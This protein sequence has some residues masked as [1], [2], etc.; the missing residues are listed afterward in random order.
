MRHDV[1]IIGAGPAGSATAILLARQGWHVTLV[2][3]H[4]FPRDKV[5]GECLS[6]LGLDCLRRMNLLEG[7][8]SLGPQVLSEAF[9]H[10]PGGRSVCLPLARPMWGISRS[11]LDE[12][13][14]QSACATGVRIIQPARCEGVL[15]VSSQGRIFPF[16]FRERAG[17]R[18]SVESRS[19]R[20][21]HRSQFPLTLALSRGERGPEI[22]LRD[23][24][25]NRVSI[26]HPSLVILADG[27][28]AL[29]PSAP[30]K[31]GDFG[32]KV[33]FEDI[34]GPRHAIE[35]FGCDGLYGGLA[36]IEGGR[37]NAAFSVPAR[38]LAKHRGDIASLF[39]QI[40]AENP[41]LRQ[42]MAGARRV[43][44]WLAAPLPRFA[45]RNNW[46]PGVIPVGNSAAALE[47]IGGEGMG[48]AL[49]SAEIVAEELSR[50][51]SSCSLPTRL[52]RRYRSQWRIRQIACRSAAWIVSCPTLA[53]LLLPL[54]GTTPG[55]AGAVLQLVGKTRAIQLAGPKPL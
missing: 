1:M 24:I 34:D 42:R 18:G 3:Q 15:S 40:V 2:E 26:E 36:A 12:F 19:T 43:S 5:C 47:P 17:V 35:L 48:L 28:S 25:T 21:E 50:S 51:D 14:L 41:I 39:S 37:W 38:R 33:H 8:R 54:L 6:A 16:S 55:L 4:R 49:C 9:I 13:L 29:M 23:L 45:V 52:Q 11:R 44:D 10:T 46:P 7:L 31:T 32:I 20:E 53:N 27:K 22:R 30:A